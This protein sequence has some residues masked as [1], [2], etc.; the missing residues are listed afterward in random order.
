MAVVIPP[1]EWVGVGA[2][3]PVVEC[4]RG[5]SW[6]VVGPVAGVGFFVV[7]R[8]FHVGEFS[9][10]FVCLNDASFFGKK[11]GVV[12]SRWFLYYAITP[13]SQKGGGGGLEERFI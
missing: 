4:I 10:L 6:M 11:G 12:G 2:W 7:F 13:S 5:L 3:G 9:C 1:P 8:R